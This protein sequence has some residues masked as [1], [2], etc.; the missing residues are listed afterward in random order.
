MNADAYYKITCSHCGG[1]IEFPATARGQTAPCPHCNK[2]IKLDNES[3]L[4]GSVGIGFFAGIIFSLII[5]SACFLTGKMG[6]NDAGVFC[7]ERRLDILQNPITYTVIFAIGIFVLSALKNKQEK[8]KNAF[9]YNTIGVSTFIIC[10]L[11]SFPYFYSEPPEKFNIDYG[12]NWALNH[13]V[14][15]P[16]TKI[17]IFD[18]YRI[19]NQYSEKVGSEKHCVYDFEAQCP[20]IYLNSD[21]NGHQFYR[22]GRGLPNSTMVVMNGSV[23]LVKK[24]Q[25]WYCTDTVRVH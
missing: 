23:T 13:S 25:N 2:N 4:A 15:W 24:G 3:N 20:L 22:Q 7:S 18:S 10:F 8:F 21:N 12:V 17:N 5:G 19:T 9:A 11:I 6:W 16:D 1:H 14:Q